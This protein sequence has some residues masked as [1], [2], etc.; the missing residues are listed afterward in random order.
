VCPS[1]CVCD[2]PPNWKTG[3]L[4]LNCLQEVE[5]CNLIGTENEAGLVRRLFDWATVLE[6]MT[7]TF[8]SSVAE[9]KGR[10]FCKMLQSFSRPAICLKGPYFA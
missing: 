7:V 8:D 3:E 2:Q 9:S 5:F 1:G 4:A 6:T 10:E